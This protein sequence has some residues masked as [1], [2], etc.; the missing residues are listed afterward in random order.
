MKHDYERMS[1]NELHE[2]YCDTFGRYFEMQWDDD[3]MHRDEV[4]ACLESGEPQKPSAVMYNL[5]DGAVA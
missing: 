2:L 4:I 1:D 3:D 5:P